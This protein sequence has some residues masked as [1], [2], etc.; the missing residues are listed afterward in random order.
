[1]A[2]ES[3]KLKEGFRERRKFVRADLY[4]VTRYF[5]PLRDKE[6][7]VHTRI[8]NISEGGALLVTFAEGVPVGPS[9]EMSFLLPG[10]NQ[11]LITVKGEVRHTHIFEKGLCR[12]GVEFSKIKEK[13]LL[14]IRKYVASAE[15][16]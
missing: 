3:K 11:G 6:V 7:G 14:A 13:D 9:I 1:M 5:C 10:D 16:K 8:S 12:S 4:A 15:K 2:K